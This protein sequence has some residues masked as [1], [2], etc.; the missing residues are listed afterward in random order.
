M[1]YEGVKEMIKKLML[2]LAA[3]LI[4]MSGITISC[5]GKEA[6]KETPTPQL[7]EAPL[8]KASAAPTKANVG[9]SISFSGIDSTDPDGT[10]T[11][12]EWDFGF[13]RLRKVLL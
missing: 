5:A 1:L 3:T 8:A 13:H 12:Y 2:V 9:E 11:S 4:L 6:E 10:I 7:K